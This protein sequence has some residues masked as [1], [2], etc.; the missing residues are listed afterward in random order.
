LTVAARPK[1]VEVLL[2]EGK[3]GDS[4]LSLET[5]RDCAVHTHVQ[6]VRDG[7]EAMSILR[8]RG[9]YRDA[10]RPALILLDLNLPKKSGREVLREVKNDPDL[11]RIP[12]VVFSTCDSKEDILTAY[13]LHANC[14]IRKPTEMSQLNAVLR[15]IEEFW[16]TR[17]RLPAD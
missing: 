17:V 5:I 15:S 1:V 12:V 14:Y 9:I 11:R 10:A 16:L 8:R 4:R 13:S 6:V 2:V 7:A 3:P